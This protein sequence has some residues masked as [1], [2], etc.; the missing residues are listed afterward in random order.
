MSY[1]SG[2]NRKQALLLPET[3]EDYVAE[4]HA[5]RAIDAFVDALD[6]GKLKFTKSQAAATG[7][8]P[9]DPADLLKLWVWGYMNRV[10][11]SRRLEVECGRNL[12]V[13]WLM[14]RLQPDFKTIADFRR[15]NAAALKSVFRQFVLIARELG[16]YGQELVAIDGTKLKASNHP[17]RRASA[18]QLEQAIKEIDA[19]IAEYL[20]AVEK[21]DSEETE[22][23]QQPVSNMVVKLE[24]LLREKTRL[25]KALSVAGAGKAPV[26]DPECQSMQKV[27]LGYNAQ[28]AVDDKHHLIAVAEIADKPTDHVQLP[29]IAAQAAEVL[30]APALKVVADA[31]YHDQE[32]VAQTEAAGLESYVPRPEKGSAET[33]GIF[34]KSAFVYEADKE[35]YRCPAGELLTRSGQGYEKKGLRYQAYTN[36]QACKACVMRA[37]CTT[38]SGKDVRRIERW[39]K[40]EV[41]EKVSKRV[42]EHPEIIR[43]RKT[44]VEHPFGT[45][46][47]WWH[48]NALLTRGKTHVQA[49]LSLSCLAYNMRR[50]LAVLG[51]DGLR[52]GLEILK[53]KVREARNGRS[54]S[55]PCGF[56][57]P[58]WLIFDLCSF[59]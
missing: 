42:E 6:L 21:S 15:D 25:E 22:Q 32:A 28:I 27:G 47:F 7:R 52:K 45:I 30:K 54:K 26:T 38:Q 43:K 31:G 18:K 4:E 29:I 11:A 24:K 44:L 49:E 17:T 40:E 23:A 19:R 1:I 36:P 35:G 2:V 50:V 59:A 53:A 8:P 55:N 14:R 34:K 12:E 9:Y 13:I 16:L 48:Q 5:V 46:K 20:N 37:Q 57:A 41:M 10:R 51:I 56:I 58:K 3:V 33:N 39:E